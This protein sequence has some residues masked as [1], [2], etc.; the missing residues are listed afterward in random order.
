MRLFLFLCFVLIYSS[1]AAASLLVVKY[2]G[3][4][5]GVDEDYYVELLD[6]A[7]K[8]TE[9][10]FGPYRIEFSRESLSSDR[11]REL[12]VAGDRVNVD[13][14]V[15]FHTTK[16]PRAA[17]LFVNVPLLRN[18]MGYRI[19]L[20]RRGTQER[21]DQ[22]KTLA[23]LKQ[24][25]LGL[26]KGWEGFIYQHNGFNLYEPITFELLLKMLAGG[27]YDFVPLAATEI[28]QTY[29]IGADEIPVTPE[30][31]LLIH[32]PLPQYFYV[33]QQCP[34]LAKRLRI[35]LK[36]MEDDGR[37][38]SIFDKYFA[39]SLKELRLQDRVI[40]EVPNPDDDGSLPAISAEEFKSY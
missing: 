6:T 21:F 40:I 25:S 13:R 35:G 29:K 34:L 3:N 2:V 11:K 31:H 26:G 24:L 15:G 16:G 39:Q 19:P 23:D 12:L 7:L 37:M 10:S 8:T 28:Q 14:L 22:V 4:N 27:R 33:S 20:I 5:A 30:Q 17:L 9:P 36:A 32:T 1:E 18:F 38:K